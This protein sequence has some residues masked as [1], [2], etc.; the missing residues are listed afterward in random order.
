ME[1]HLNIPIDMSN[2][3]RR[4]R[5]NQRMKNLKATDHSSIPNSS[6]QRQANKHMI[7]ELYDAIKDGDVDRF[8]DAL[9]RVLLE[10]N[11]SLT[12]ISDQVTPSENSMLHV[13]ITF[14]HE[15]IAKLVAHHFPTLINRRNICG[16]TALHIA[17]RT[18][19]SNSNLINALLERTNM[20]DDQSQESMITITRIKNELGNTALHEAVM[21]RGNLN[22]VGTLVK[23]DPEVVHYLN[24]AGLKN[25]QMQSGLLIKI[26][27]GTI[28]VAYKLLRK[29]KDLTPPS[30]QDWMEL[31]LEQKLELMYSKDE[32][33][34]NPL[35]YAARKGYLK[36]V[37]LLL[38]KDREIALE[39]NSKGLLPIHLACKE[40]HIDVVKEFLQQE[41][42]HP[43][44][45]LSKSGQNILHIAAKSRK[46]HVVKYIL[47]NKNLEKLLDQQDRKGNTP[48]HLAA[49]S[50]YPKTVLFLTH[51][52]RHKIQVQNKENLKPIDVV[53]LRS[54]N[55]YSNTFGE[56]LTM[57]ILS[58][59]GSLLSWEEIKVYLLSRHKQLPQTQ[60][61][62][63]RINTLLLVSILVA[64][65]TFAAGFTVPGGTDD[66]HGT[67][68][69]ENNKMFQTFIICD[70]VAM[71]TSIIGTFFLLLA[72]VN[73]RYLAVSSFY[74]ALFF[75]V[76]A[77]VAMSLAFTAAAYLV[78]RNTAWLAN[79]IL[80]VGSFFLSTFLIGLSPF[81]LWHPFGSGLHFSLQNR[82]WYSFVKMIIQLFG[83]YETWVLG[84]LAY[85]MEE[86]DSETEGSSQQKNNV[87]NK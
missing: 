16:D 72:Q 46:D 55:P 40:G 26:W 78:V 24:E 25:E 22:Q 56:L 38:K 50:M 8:V 17:A 73:Y 12:A 37:R 82:I 63:D 42:L 83:S 59:D 21:I 11:L 52:M 54:K 4:A 51:A 29:K 6:G 75:V 36:G 85:D 14:G 49:E 27:C 60:L 71:Y 77:L 67:A 41:W 61:Y 68:I 30:K 62:K 86:S 5:C 84:K 18:P 43:I 47:R 35:H 70:M 3:S 80:V 13:A 87:I 15:E 48:L 34:N 74:L 33:G 20:N 66:K 31:I 7:H 28:H 44:E 79:F 19:R 1:D 9:E 64:T 65:V 69:M 39:S 2:G 57:Y 81:F 23:E 58:S 32:E 76:L 53:H 45:L 10:K